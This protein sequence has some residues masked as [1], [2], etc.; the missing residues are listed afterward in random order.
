MHYFYIEK[1]GIIFAG[2][3]EDWKDNAPMMFFHPSPVGRKNG[4]IK[5]G[6]ASGLPQ[7]GMNEKGLF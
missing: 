2:N 6:W 5:F 4:W 3:D 7:G 1:E